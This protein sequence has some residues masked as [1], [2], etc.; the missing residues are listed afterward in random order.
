[1]TPTPPPLSPESQRAVTQERLRLLSLGY[2]I[3]GAIGAVCVSFLIIH[4]AVFTAI[5]LVPASVW[6]NK[7][8]TQN[9]VQS[10]GTPDHYEVHSNAPPAIVF[11][12]L[13]GVI[14]I[15]ILI[16]WTLGGLTIYAGR[17]IKLRQRHT[18]VMTMA[19]VNCI[20]IP[21]G[22]L[23]GVATFLTLGSP[24]AKEEY[25]TQLQESRN[26]QH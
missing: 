5:S 24:D 13:A 26:E 23:L 8:S 3:S 2:Y 21:Y 14:G 19:C 7:S 18:F 12:I 22:T 10:D 1:M 9:S 15:I 11:R 25:P 20:W 16:G 17:C 4:M 6:N